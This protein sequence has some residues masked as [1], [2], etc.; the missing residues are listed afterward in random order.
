V[1]RLRGTGAALLVALACRPESPAR[2]RSAPQESASRSATP[3]GTIATVETT[4][5]QLPLSLPAQLYVEHDATVY[6]RSTGMVEAILVDLGTRVAARQP[7]AR[8]ESADQE[9]ALRQAK[10]KFSNARQTLERQRALAAAGVVTRADSEQVEFDYRQAELDLQKAQRDLDLTRIVSPFAGVVTARQARVQRLV[11]TGDSLFRVTGLEPIL[12]A[13]HLPES[14]SPGVR[15]GATA[16]V[17]APGGG[18]AQ[19]RVVRASPIIDAGSGTREVVLRLSPGSGL[20]PGSSVTVRLGSERRQVVAIPRG[21]VAS[22][23]YALVWQDERTSLRAVTLG[24]E[25]EGD[26]VEVLSGLAP[27]EKVVLAAQ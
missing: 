17:F 11:R 26:R 25:L 27:G 16:E 12:A 4:T 18:R 21:A 2:P 5:V 22:D 9:I 24:A 6:A 7:L 1:R 20:I 13:I 23:G 15:V 8:L 14:A 10:E 19:A 3:A